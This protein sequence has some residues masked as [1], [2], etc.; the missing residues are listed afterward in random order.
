M[1]TEVGKLAPPSVSQVSA[2]LSA[3]SVLEGPCAHRGMGVEGLGTEPT[4]SPNS[5]VA[6]DHLR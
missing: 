6:G 4:Q 2:M 5:D 1:A 3:W